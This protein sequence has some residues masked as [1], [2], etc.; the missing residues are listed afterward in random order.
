[1]NA[2]SRGTRL[3]SQVMAAVLPADGATVAT[4]LSLG[5]VL[6]AHTGNAHLGVPIDRAFLRGLARAEGDADDAFYGYWAREQ[7]SGSARS[8][9]ADRDDDPD[10]AFVNPPAMIPFRRANAH[11]FAAS[12]PDIH[13]TLHATRDPRRPDVHVEVRLDRVLLTELARHQH[14]LYRKIHFAVLAGFLVAVAAL[15]ALALLLT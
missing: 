8:E 6:V 13:L 9:P 5:P 14:R 2:G 4:S 7:V 12:G 11:T 15:V 1:M 10:V 3:D